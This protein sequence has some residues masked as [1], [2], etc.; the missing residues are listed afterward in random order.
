M[1]MLRKLDARPPRSQNISLGDAA[2]FSVWLDD[3]RAQL[4][5]KAFG[6]ILSG[7]LL[8]VLLTALMIDLLP[9]GP[10]QFMLR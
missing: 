9:R 2:E 1:P 4:L 3:A 8:L 10:L 6:T 5:R 7:I